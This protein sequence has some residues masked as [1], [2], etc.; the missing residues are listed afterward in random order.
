MWVRLDLK[1]SAAFLHH[2]RNRSELAHHG[3]SGRYALLHSPYSQRN[4]DDTLSPMPQNPL[5]FVETLVE[6][7]GPGAAAL[8][9]D[10]SCW[11]G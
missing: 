2:H 5:G 4:I 11:Q 7:I 3:Q 9:M 10:R 8:V 1:P 6:K